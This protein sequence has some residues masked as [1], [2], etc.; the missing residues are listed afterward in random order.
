MPWWPTQ[1]T[2]VFPR[3]LA[4]ALFPWGE[5]SAQTIA[6]VPSEANLSCST[7]GLSTAR[8]RTTSIFSIALP[9]A[10]GS[11]GSQLLPVVLPFS[12]P[13]LF[14]LV[15]SLLH[16]VGLPV[17][18]LPVQLG[19]QWIRTSTKYF[20]WMFFHRCL[21]QAFLPLC[22]PG[23]GRNSDLL[24]PEVLVLKDLLP[25]RIPRLRIHPAQWSWYALIYLQPCL[26]EHPWHVLSSCPVLCRHDQMPASRVQKVQL[27]HP[28]F[29][30]Y[31]VAEVDQIQHHQRWAKNSKRS[32]PMSEATR[33]CHH[34]AQEAAV[35]L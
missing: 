7:W 1:R 21:R 24:C 15:R 16:V 19:F 13:C 10:F 31:Q 2:L 18:V 25:H 30:R 6:I 35:V 8:T 27:L 11:E 32:L 17:D 5:A 23:Y 9:F 20:S 3:D 4:H 26:D 29:P 28:G 14:P 12:F 22:H 34:L 33:T